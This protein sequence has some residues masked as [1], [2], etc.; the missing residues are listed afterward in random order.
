MIGNMQGISMPDCAFGAD[1]TGRT[2]LRY[3]LAAAEGRN[4]RSSDEKTPGT[5][6]P[7][8]CRPSTDGLRAGDAA[9]EVVDLERKKA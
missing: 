5:P 1:V 9:R 8:L 7:A 4:V 6:S 3:L 2:L